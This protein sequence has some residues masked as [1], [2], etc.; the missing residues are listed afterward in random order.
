MWDAWSWWLCG[1]CRCFRAIAL[2]HLAGACA[3]ARACAVPLHARLV[4]ARPRPKS[5]QAYAGAVLRH[6]AYL[7]DSYQTSCRAPCFLGA[8]AWMDADLIG[9]EQA[10]RLC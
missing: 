3:L 9:A 2:L 4:A 5:G 10:K 1:E 6:V 7:Q 8:R